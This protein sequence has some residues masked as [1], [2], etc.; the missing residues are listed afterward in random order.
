MNEI[1]KL[2]RLEYVMELL[3]LSAYA[4]GR[5]TDVDHSLI[6]KWQRGERKMT[7]RSKKLQAVSGVL[8]AAD[9]GGVLEPLL[10]PY[11]QQGET[12]VEAM[13]NYLLGDEQPALPP[14][15]EKPQRQITGDY[16]K[17]TRVF[18]GKKGFRKAILAIM[19]YVQL[20]PPGCEIIGLCQG[21]YDWIVE[22]MSFVV[23]FI[24]Q[25]R[26]AE[27]R[28][29]HLTMINRK[30]Y[31][32]AETAAFA[33]PWLVAHLR[34]YIRSLYYEG[35]LP[36]DIRFAGSI[37]GY[38][39]IRVI[40]DP[41]VE[42][43]L[44]VEMTTDPRDM[45]RDEALC[46]TYRRM[47][48]PAS[49]YAFLQSPAGDGANAQLWQPGGLPQI[50]DQTPDGSF[51]ALSRVPSFGILGPKE[52]DYLLGGDP[53]PEIPS[54][55]LA[56]PKGLT[57]GSY[58]I[59][60][61]REDVREGLGMEYRRNEPLSM[62]LHRDVEV[63]KE[64]LQ[65]QIRRLI[66]AMEANAEFEVALMPRVAFAKMQLEMVCWKDSASVG[67][68]QNARQSVYADDQ[69]TSGSFY[70]AIGFGW[71]KLLSGWKRKERVL[72]Q[73]RKW[74][75]GNDLDIVETD[76]TMVRNW[77]ILPGRDKQP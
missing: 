72:R 56:S 24:E 57:Q 21:R 53:M 42:D 49:Q 28:G 14:R 6:S 18:M 11:R 16:V 25:L 74:V 41:E 77:S 33:G 76:S 51:W 17:E 62:L 23:Q 43:S 67:W 19:E 73:L 50:N 44:Y 2:N 10:A 4:V 60:L 32:V 29:T 20:L 65:A 55:M 45:R 9:K 35:S 47:S 15:T 58:R 52:F 27:R 26:K 1:G 48:E 39:S 5:L 22:D 66:L 13:H 59:V 54:Y 38:C 63:P 46:E 64:I 34:G 30:G 36:S 68:L 69:A 12:E 75:D 71:D 31:S 8:V 40:E 70:G 61:C 7:P 3:G 37:A